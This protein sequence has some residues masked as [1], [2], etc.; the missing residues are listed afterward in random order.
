MEAL[1]LCG[2][3]CCGGVGAAW[4]VAVGGGG[5][6]GMGVWLWVSGVR[7]VCVGAV[8]KIGLAGLLFMV[9]A[10]GWA[11]VVDSGALGCVLFLANIAL[12]GSGGAEF[13]RFAN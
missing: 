9:V 10:G 12:A 1:V 8:W 13:G 6:G 5:G 2:S 7:L 11:L 4:V 3:G